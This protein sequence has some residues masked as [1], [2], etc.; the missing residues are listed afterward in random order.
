MAVY[1]IIN[2]EKLAASE[3]GVF[4][5]RLRYKEAEV[6]HLFMEIFAVL[7]VGN[8]IFRNQRRGLTVSIFN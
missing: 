5:G 7:Q 4:W 2:S 1:N 6:L 3:H 8:I